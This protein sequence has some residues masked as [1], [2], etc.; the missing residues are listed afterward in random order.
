AV[1]VG[2]GTDAI[3]LLLRG[4]GVGPGDE[5]ITAPVS[6]AY[7]ALA[8]QMAGAT[9]V[10]A[11]L[12]GRRMTLDPR[13]AEAAITPKTKAIL[14]VHLY[15]QPA[16]LPA[17]KAIADKYRLL[18]VEDACQSHFATCGGKPV[19]SFGAGAAYSFYPTKN[20]G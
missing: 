20:L 7:S 19:G 13:A 2:T 4:L 8:I 10:F 17:L 1:G 14:P 3:A 9:P 5:V 6:A 12:D 16:D 11:D 18:L 15:G